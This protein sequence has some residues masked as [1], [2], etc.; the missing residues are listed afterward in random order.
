MAAEQIRVDLDALDS[1]LTSMRESYVPLHGIRYVEN[2]LDGFPRA[3]KALASYSGKWDQRRG[4]LMDALF[5]LTDV[6]QEVRTT[7][8]EVDAAYAE[9]LRSQS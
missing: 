1:L 8:A 3:T 4:E 2:R 9:P 6:L 5:V 7:F